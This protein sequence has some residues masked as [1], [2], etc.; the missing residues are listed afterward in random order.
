MTNTTLT[1]AG[2]ALGAGT[3]LALAGA[4]PASAHVG[5]SASTT[6]AGSYALLSFS[7]PHGCDG[8]PTTAISIE[9]PEEISA[10]TPTVVAGWEASKVTVEVAATTDAHGNEVTERVAQVVYTATDGGLPD[11][12]RQQFDVQALLPDLEAGT[13]LSFPVTQTCEVGETVWE[14]EDTPTITLSAAVADAHG[15]DDDS[16][17]HDAAADEETAASEAGT[18]S[19]TDVLA[20]VLGI[21]GLVVG[22]AGI[23]AAVVARRGIRSES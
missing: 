22:T 11:G 4:L 21:G 5:V 3:L 1:K 10:A 16:D 2:I 6:A 12:Y 17:E 23:V 7:V 15:H 13:T 9:W 18:A 14:G 20:R 19:S 8:S